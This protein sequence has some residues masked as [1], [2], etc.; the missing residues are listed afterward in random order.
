MIADEK[1]VIRYASESVQLVLGYTAEE[2]IGKKVFDYMYEADKD[3]GKAFL[4]KVLTEK[5]PLALLHRTIDKKGSI[6]FMRTTAN[7]LLDNPTIRGIV[8][9]T[10]DVTKTHKREIETKE[11]KEYLQRTINSVSELVFCL[12]SKGKIRLWNDQ[13]VQLTGFSTRSMIGKDL[14]KTA[15]IDDKESFKTYLET[16]MHK[17]AKPYDLK[18]R[19]KHD[20]HRL[21]RIQGS[22]VKTDNETDKS[23]VFTRKDVTYDTE[24]HGSLITGSS[25][26]I[27][28]TSNEKA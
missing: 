11:M 20:E 14:F 23:I 26:L 1:G 4:S 10:Q 24:I 22:V 17:L 5:T 21:I 15:I 6:R 19:T 12:T 2:M 16:C 9:T 18:I 27:P 25:Y 13:I 7:N 3:K 28:E 8:V